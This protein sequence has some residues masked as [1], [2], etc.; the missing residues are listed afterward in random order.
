MKKQRREADKPRVKAE[1]KE[2]ALFSRKRTAFEVG[3][4]AGPVEEP[5]AGT[6]KSSL[7]SRQSSSKGAE[8]AKGPST[9]RFAEGA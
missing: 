7:K 6:K 9:V 8:S 2:P 4:A 1:Q 3:V 5:G